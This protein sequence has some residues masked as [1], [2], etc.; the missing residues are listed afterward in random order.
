[1]AESR[2]HAIRRADH[3]I[4]PI[5]EEILIEIQKQLWTS[6]VWNWAGTLQRMTY[7]AILLALRRGI[8]VSNYTKVQPGKEDHCI[9]AEDVQF[10]VLVEG[11]SEEFE[12]VV[13]SGMQGVDA[14][15]VV[16]FT[17]KVKRRRRVRRYLRWCLSARTVPTPRTASSLTYCWSAC[18]ARG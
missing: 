4:Y 3:A 18:N 9:R 11:G 10:H 16:G 7:A 15:Q 5:R 2:E 13:A 8:R 6:T 12:L 1:M 17:T 14:A